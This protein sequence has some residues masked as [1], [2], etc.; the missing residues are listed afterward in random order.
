MKHVKVLSLLLVSASLMAP[1]PSKKDL[2]RLKGLTPEERRLAHQISSTPGA[3][4]GKGTVRA[5]R[6]ES[7]RRRGG[8]AKAAARAKGAGRQAEREA[9]PEGGAGAAAP[10]G[11][12]ASSRLLELV[13]VGSS[14]NGSGAAAEDDDEKKDDTFQPGHRR[15]RSQSE[16]DL[17]AAAAQGVPD[18]EQDLLAALT[19]RY[20]NDPA[21][22]I[23]LTRLVARVKL[24][25]ADSD[26]PR[27]RT[28]RPSRRRPAGA[29]PAPG[30]A[31][32]RGALA[33]LGAHAAAQ[34]AA[35]GVDAGS[36]LPTDDG[37]LEA[38][39]AA[40]ATAG[41]ALPPPVVEDS[42]DELPPPPLPGEED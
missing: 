12:S 17:D 18:T 20:E 40:A 1:P 34:N 24:D 6:L 3:P 23:L 13:G 41:A 33:A 37:D 2:S 28:R 21:A 39:L 36:G 16:N 9:A 32:I 8:P 14:K 26:M 22:L 38:V 15:R 35:A 5:V 31:T 4:P 42:A 29:P 10:R 25:C 11:R 19:K 27:T 7:A 30:D